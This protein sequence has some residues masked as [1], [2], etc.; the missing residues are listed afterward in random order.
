MR[1]CTS[2]DRE[3]VRTNIA[4]ALSL[5]HQAAPNDTV[6][7]FLA[8]H[9]DNEGSDY[10]FISADAARESASGDVKALQMQNA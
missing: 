7:V 3:R 4:A 2:G 5:L 10:F 1:Q 8:A 9:G 6:V